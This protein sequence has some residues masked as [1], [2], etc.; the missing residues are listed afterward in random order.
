VPKFA[1]LALVVPTLAIMTLA[2]AT[3]ALAATGV[4]V[5]VAP[6]AELPQ[7]SKSW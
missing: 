6:T 1:R 2:S 7:R 4:S 5:S 3:V